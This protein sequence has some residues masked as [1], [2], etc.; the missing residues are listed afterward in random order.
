MPLSDSTA[1]VL[2]EGA[3]LCNQ[4]EIQ[5]LAFHHAAITTIRH[6]YDRF[7][8]QSADAGSRSAGRYGSQPHD[9]FTIR[10]YREGDPEGKEALAA[11]EALGEDWESIVESGGRKNC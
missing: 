1:R 3:S 9:A 11:R 4:T 8:V 7:I 6:G 10:M 5:E 2:V